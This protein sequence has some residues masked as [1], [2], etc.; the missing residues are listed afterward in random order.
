MVEIGG[1][2]SFRNENNKGFIGTRKDC[3][4][5]KAFLNKVGE[6]IFDGVVSK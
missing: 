3:M 2:F 4:K 1:L 6:L 5:T